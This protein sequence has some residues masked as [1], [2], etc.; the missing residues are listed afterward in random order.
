MDYQDVSVATPSNDYLSRSKAL[1]SGDYP[2]Y[3]SLCDELGVRPEDP[4]AY[5]IGKTV[6]NY[7]SQRAANEDSKILEMLESEE[8]E[9]LGIPAA[10]K[11]PSTTVPRVRSSRRG[12][13][14]NGCEP[15]NDRQRR[16]SGDK[17]GID[18]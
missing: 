4:L 10:P 6:I 14:P 18:F 17:P 2:T 8:R 12:A 3:A 1:I 15:R 13:I 9:A 16:A 11:F 5:E 7:H